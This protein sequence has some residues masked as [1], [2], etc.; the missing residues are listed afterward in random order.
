MLAM[1]LSLGVQAQVEMKYSS[2]VNPTIPH[3]AQLMYTES[4]DPEQVV[5][6]YKA[7]YKIH[8]FVKNQHTQYYKR[9]LRSFSRI[10]Y[11]YEPNSAEFTKRKQNESAYLQNSQSKGGV[12]WQSIGPF[13]FDKDA[14]SRSYAPGAAHVYTV[15]QSASNPNTI[16][17][18]TANAGV[19]KSTD[20]GLNWVCLTKGMML[21][22][23]FS[24]EIHPTSP[25]TVLFCGDGLVYKTTDGGINWVLTTGVALGVDVRDI[26]MDPVNPNIVFLSSNNGFY[27]STNGGS[28]WTQIF[29]GDFQEVELHPTNHNTVYLIQQTGN[30]TVFRRSTD[31]GLTFTTAA[32]TGWPV[33]ASADEQKRTE[34]ATTPAAP[35]NVYALCTGAAD[36]GSGLYGIYFSSDQGQ[37]WT[38]RCCGTGPGGVPSP[39]NINMMG[40]D[41][42]GQDDG[43]QYYYDLAMDVSDTDPQEIHVA[44]VNRWVSTDGG[45]NFICPS[46]WSEPEK[47]EYIHAD[48]HDIRF[49]GADMWIACDGG[50]FYSK[51][52][53]DTVVR[54]MRGIE[55]TDF[56]GFGATAGPNKVMLGGTYHNGTLLKDEDAYEEGWL[57]TMGGDNIRGFV[58]FANDRL[59]YHDYG[60]SI[61]SGD[62]AL[63]LNTS[64]FPTQP[65]ASYIVGESSNYEFHPHSQN[66]I[67]FGNE[68][69]L[70]KTDGNG[71]NLQVIYDFGE[72][73]TSVEIAPS[74]KDIIYVCTYPGWWDTKHVWRS[75]NG[76][77]TFA[78]ITPP[79]ALINGQEWVPYDIAIS[80][81]D[82]NIVW[83]AR[84]SQYGNYPSELE[85]FRI[86]KST[87]GGTTWTNYTGTA[88]LDG[89]DITNI[90][91]QRGSNGG[92]W[93][94]TRRAVY[95]RNVT[96]ADWQLYNSG[97]PASTFSTQLAL[98]YNQ[99]VLWNATNRSVY[100]APLIEVNPPKAQLAADK[101][102]VDC[103]DNVVHFADNSAMSMQNAQWQW[104]FP[105]GTPA[106]STLQN[107]VVTYNT[108]GTYAVTLKVTDVN[109]TDTQTINSFITF[110]ASAVSPVVMQDFETA[111][112]PNPQ[113]KLR[114][115]NQTFDWEVYNVTKGPDCLPTNALRVNNYNINNP[116]DEAYLVSPAISLEGMI[117]PAVS[118]YYAFATYPD[119]PDGFRVEVSTDCGQ[120]WATLFT[121]QGDDLTT[122]APSTDE[123]APEN[124]SDWVQK[125]HSLS[126]YIGDTV[127][128]RFAAINAYG[129]NFYLDNIN[130]TAT[131][132]AID[133][134]TLSATQIFPNPSNGE[135]F[136]RTSMKNALLTVYSAD[137]KQV[138]SNRFTEGTHRFNL[139]V[140]AGIYVAKIENG[141]STKYLKIIVK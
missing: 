77:Q 116:G 3:W 52:A 125:T 25:N 14:E 18:G 110:N 101:F 28:N 85:G 67:Y 16:Y 118:Y 21:N 36:G 123:Y 41:D 73:V 97:L 119:Y 112:F 50:I 44:G 114:N 63:P 131:P 2:A 30:K 39:S 117:N 134:E 115:S 124:C 57:S 111:N 51:S 103:F 19:W 32:P 40:W 83:L 46:K 47:K 8:T 79:T 65:N 108:P 86:F 107:P 15:E 72:E 66:I 13:D 31:N 45:Y 104:T 109:G 122:I 17:A 89:E 126:N 100:E 90:E 53:G 12:V 98:N 95:Y 84:T 76:G 24:I 6:E 37:T 140:T 82:P 99:G 43:G 121:A 20:K 74:N 78:N 70:V 62:R 61:L 68:N 42:A 22:Y 80:D 60:K 129:N 7:Y 113:W 23:V 1:L 71:G 81:V 27:R 120:T 106:T 96:M 87:N 91:Y 4:P 88:S 35:N 38:F 33:P 69:R 56:W 127:Y 75:T 5:K 138:Y 105:G 135:F 93:L 29:G 137:G 34:I 130:I 58:N 128:I 133:E 26:V 132:D 94:G 55:G 49:F 136:L 10:N 54:R 9:W 92:V 102:T 59:V 141:T 48:I 11:P 64:S 139:N